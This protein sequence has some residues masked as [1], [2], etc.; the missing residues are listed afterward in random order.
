MQW[1]RV[2]VEFINVFFFVYMTG[3]AMFLFFSAAAGSVVMH[4][5]AKNARFRKRIYLEHHE[6]YMPVSLIVPAYNE[7]QTILDAVQSL[8]KLDYG[9]Y[10]VIVVNDGS[11]DGTE[12]ALIEFFHMQKVERPIRRQVPSKEVVSVWETTDKGVPITLITKVNGGKADALNMGINASKYGYFL[13]MDADSVLQ[14]DALK[15]LME[16]FI[17]DD[18]VVACGGCIQ[19]ANQAVIEDGEIKGNYF[20]KK[21][22]V[23]FQMLEYCRSFLGSRIFFD[24]YGGN[25]IISGACG[26]FRKDI[27]VKAGGY[28]TGIIGEDMEIVVKLHDYCRSNGIPY[29]IVNEQLAICWTQVP[30]S[31]RDLRK[32]RRRW[33]LGMIQSI[34][35]HQSLIFNGEYGLVSFLS[36]TYYLIMESLGPVIELIGIINIILAMR[37]EMIN[38]DFMITYYFL[39]LLF[40]AAVTMITFFSRMYLMAFRV[41]V[42]QVIKVILASI[43][44]G[45]GFRQVITLFRLSAFVNY[46][47]N[48]M[49]W[50]KITRKEHQ[51]QEKADKEGED[52]GKE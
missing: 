18:K 49:E 41:T 13:S 46:R 25:L 20:P 34:A 19:M 50:G 31:M 26:L 33:H 37:L 8:R 38:I 10:E 30:E 29:K 24:T 42:W 48:K 36:M 7:E 27:V 23:L 35:L 32:Q 15:K 16:R 22:V 6:L 52:E 2:I 43:A 39:F 5:K 14:R 17:E 47:K 4:N 12:Q 40:S 1:I 3:Y 11:T 51:R 28:N 44:E 45:L 9:E 21:L